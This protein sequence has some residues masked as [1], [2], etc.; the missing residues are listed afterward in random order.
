MADSYTNFNP[1]AGDPGQSDHSGEPQPGDPEYYEQQKPEVSFTKKVEILRALLVTAKQYNQEYVASGGIDGET[2]FIGMGAIN[3]TRLTTGS[4]VKPID[5]EMMESFKKLFQLGRDNAE[6]FPDA[7]NDAFGEGEDVLDA[8]SVLYYLSQWRTT[9]LSNYMTLPPDDYNRVWAAGPDIMGVNANAAPTNSSTPVFKGVAADVPDVTLNK[10]PSILIKLLATGKG[11]S[12]GLFSSNI[13]SAVT[14]N[15]LPFI[16]KRNDQRIEQEPVQGWNKV[17]PVHGNLM[18]KDIE[19]NK[20]QKAGAQDILSE[21]ENYLGD[22]PFQLYLFRKF[23]NYF[24]YDI[25]NGWSWDD[26]VVREISYMSQS[27]EDV[28]KQYQHLPPAAQ[29]SKQ[30]GTG[31]EILEK[32]KTKVATDMFGHTF[33]SVTEER[34]GIAGRRSFELVTTGRDAAAPKPYKLYTVKG[35]LGSGIEVER[36]PMTG[37]ETEQDNN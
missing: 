4:E 24:N 15:T 20:I 17:N 9:P 28:P 18:V 16:D 35:E 29:R 13:S 30:N 5:R 34:A 36:D 37:C 22:K 8:Y 11:S 27:F 14:E 21:I 12:Q 26:Y 31:T 32:K 19:K 10:C 33:D 7:L 3:Q 6:K 1:T 2:P 23:V 25:N